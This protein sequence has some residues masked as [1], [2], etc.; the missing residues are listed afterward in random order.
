MGT[1]KTN[2]IRSGILY[3]KSP[4]PHGLFLSI[5]DLVLPAPSTWREMHTHQEVHTNAL[6]PVIFLR[7]TINFPLILLWISLGRPLT[8]IS[9]IQDP[10]EQDMTPCSYVC[11]ALP[12][13]LSGVWLNTQWLRLRGPVS[14]MEDLQPYS[15]HVDYPYATQGI[16]GRWQ[17]RHSWSLYL[18]Q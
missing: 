14:A 4:T 16:N 1:Y 11:M 8:A 2:G 6:I 10:N 18:F 12:F 9:E 13:Y 15:G 17:F 3:L 7:R 5:P